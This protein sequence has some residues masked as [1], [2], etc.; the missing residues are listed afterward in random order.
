V[1][2]AVAAQSHEASVCAYEL[3]GRAQ[4]AEAEA[5]ALR[6]SAEFGGGGGGGGGGGAAGRYCV[7]GDGALAGDLLAQVQSLSARLDRERDMRRGDLAAF[8][9][10]C[11]AERAA[12]RNFA[13]SPPLPPPPPPSQRPPHQQYQ[14]EQWSAASPRSAPYLPRAAAWTGGSTGNAAARSD[15]ANHGTARNAE[16][17]AAHA[18]ALWRP[19]RSAQLPLPQHRHRYL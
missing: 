5:E 12:A 10:A 18:A 1:A 7:G 14:R 9:A 16:A 4:A 8:D 11:G 17:A 2:A 15:A 13:L 19:V 3:L 6:C